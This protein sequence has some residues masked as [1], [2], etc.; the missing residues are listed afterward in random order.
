MKQMDAPVMCQ[1]GGA[2][3][4]RKLLRSPRHR[5]QRYRI[6]SLRCK[7]PHS[8]AEAY[9]WPTNNAPSPRYPL[10]HHVPV[11]V[12]DFSARRLLLAG[13]PVVLRLPRRPL[14]RPSVSAD[15]GDGVLH[16]RAASGA[17][18][19]SDLSPSERG[20]ALAH[21]SPMYSGGGMLPPRA[22][23]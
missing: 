2:K 16:Q 4:D 10:G 12:S 21:P 19:L 22:A 15:S 14:F 9:N 20:T 5:S 23:E 11:F 7:S 17:N 1:S 8:V 6:G 3:P 18:Y 13:S